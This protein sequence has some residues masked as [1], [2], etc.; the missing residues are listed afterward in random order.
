MEIKHKLILAIS[1]VWAFVILVLGCVYL[2]M[3]STKVWTSNGYEQV[4]L[5]GSAH[6]KWQ[7]IRENI[8]IKQEE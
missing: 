8:S 2:D 5:P 6:Y 4:M 3:Q 1:C 7:K